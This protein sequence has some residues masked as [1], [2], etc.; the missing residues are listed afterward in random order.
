MSRVALVTCAELPDLPEDDRPLIGELRARGIEAVPAIWNE[1][2]VDWVSFD[3]TVIRSPWDYDDDLEGFLEWTRQAVNLW[4]RPSTVEW[5][6]DK[7]YLTRLD[8]DTIDTVWLERGAAPQRP[9]ERMV[10]KAVV[11]LGGRNALLDPSDAELAGLVAEHD[12][13]L[14]PFMEEVVEHGELSLVFVDGRFEHA[15]RKRAGPGEFR[16][17]EEWGGWI[18]PARAEPEQVAIG[19]RV[20]AGLEETLYARVDLIGDRVIEVELTEPSLFLGAGP[21]TAG[22]MAVAIAR[23]LQ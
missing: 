8:V 3:M 20:L 14:Q 4:N 11:D 23:R 21:S 7:R 5:N 1:P 2:A 13:M 15:A 10:A 17:Q 16:T 18:E 22:A 9:W 12:V 19:E 6:L